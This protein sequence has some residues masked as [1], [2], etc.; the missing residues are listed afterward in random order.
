MLHKN[1]P[2]CEGSEEVKTPL[3]LRSMIFWAAPALLAAIFWLT[4]LMISSDGIQ[5]IMLQSVLLSS[6]PWLMLVWPIWA[7]VI[8]F[9]RRG[10]WK[11]IFLLIFQKG[12]MPQSILFGSR[13]QPESAFVAQIFFWIC[14]ALFSLLVF[15][16]IEGGTFFTGLLFDHFVR[17]DFH[18]TG[19]TQTPA[20]HPTAPPP[21]TFYVYGN[22]INPTH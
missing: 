4:G 6:P 1:S 21:L 8:A 19:G 18:G 22:P 7:L 2:S 5:A 20:P 16:R 3:N 14:A 10:R 15:H 9:K 11:W 13:H 12:T 17:L